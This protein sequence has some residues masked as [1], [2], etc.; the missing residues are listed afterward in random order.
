MAD[1]IDWEGVRRAY[2]A[3]EEPLR[4]IRAR[5]GVGV[6]AL[7]ERR[8]AEGWTPRSAA[9]AEMGRFRLAGLRKEREEMEARGEAERA[10]PNT[11]PR[12]R[13]GMKRQLTRKKTA[14]LVAALKT[15]GRRAQKARRRLG[16]ETGRPA[17]DSQAE[18]GP[19]QDWPAP[20][21]MAQDGPAESVQAEGRGAEDMEAA[22]PDRSRRQRRAG[23]DAPERS[24][25]LK[26]P[27]RRACPE[28]PGRPACPKEPEAHGRTRKAGGAAM[29]LLALAEAEIDRLEKLFSQEGRIVEEKD[30]RMLGEAARMLDRAET[31]AAK[32]RRRGAGPAGI[33]EGGA[34]AAE[35]EDEEW[36]R[37]ELER[38]LQGLARRAGPHG[39][40]G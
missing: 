8:I 35:R 37:S 17:Q 20:E 30:L 36:M 33:D 23:G 29:R 19:A 24:A 18:G 26:A 1:E 7:R 10:N 5:F 28:M 9:P 32:R 11:L 3:G 40:A 27:E 21:R 16:E 39:R 12:S 15:G 31:M 13:R 25:G 22:P 4:R 2:E 6:R 38:R 34:A 14:R